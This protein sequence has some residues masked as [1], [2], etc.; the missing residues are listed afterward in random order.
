MVI[1]N[2][3]VVTR[4]A[5]SVKQWVWILCHWSVGDSKVPLNMTHNCKTESLS[6]NKVS[7]TRSPAVLTPDH[8]MPWEGQGLGCWGE[9]SC[10]ALSAWL[11]RQCH[12]QTLRE[13][14]LEMDQNRENKSTAG[15]QLST[16][17]VDSIHW[18]QHHSSVHFNVL[19]ISVNYLLYYIGE[20][21]GDNIWIHL[22]LRFCS[23]V[24]W[25]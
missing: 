6:A 9:D 7:L 3:W 16:E 14:P 21:Q 10:R 22:D 23:H 13:Q 2:V 12:S 5:S 8:R 17:P 4:Y 24:K 25:F 15:T 20:T 11:R 19:E 1:Y 18:P